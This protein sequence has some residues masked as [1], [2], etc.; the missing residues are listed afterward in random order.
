[1]GSDDITAGD[2]IP[3]HQHQNED[4]ILFIH[5]GHGIATVGDHEQPVDRG[6]TIYVPRGTWHGVRNE[7]TALT[8]IQLLWIFSSPGMDDYFRAISTPPGVEP[9]ARTAEETE[10]EERKHGIRYEP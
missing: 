4:E 2:G 7:A 9:R 10:D 5:A 6:A 1:M 8:P 3:V